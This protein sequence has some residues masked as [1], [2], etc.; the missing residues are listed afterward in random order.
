[1]HYITSRYVTILTQYKTRESNPIK[2]KSITMQYN[3][4]LAQNNETRQ[5]K[6]FPVELQDKQYYTI[7]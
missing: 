3:R 1:M 6:Q 5:T 2:H 4:G 7:T